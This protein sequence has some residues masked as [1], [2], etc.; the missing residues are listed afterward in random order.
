MALAGAA[1]QRTTAHHLQTILKMVVSLLSGPAR[2]SRLG[3]VA[4]AQEAL[5]SAL[6]ATIKLLTCEIDC[7]TRYHHLRSSLPATLICTSH[8]PPSILQL[9]A[10]FR[11]THQTRLSMNNLPVSRVTASKL[12]LPSVVSTSA[13]AEP[14][15]APWSRRQAIAKL[16]SNH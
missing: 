10:S 16:S 9:S 13:M 3:H 8:S 14:P 7:A 2:S 15:G 1:R 6:S 12:G 5:P 4:P 11:R